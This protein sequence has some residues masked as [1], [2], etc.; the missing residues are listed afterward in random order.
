MHDFVEIGILQQRKIEAEIIKPIYDIMKRELGIEKAQAIIAEA[1]SNAAIETGQAFAKNTE[2][3]VTLESFVDLQYL[4][5]KGN[6]LTIDV[7]NHSAG[8][9]QYDVTHCRYAEM[10][11]EMGLGEIGFLLS[12]NRD[13]QFIKGYAP[14]IH[15]ERPKT[16][17]EGYATCGFH[18]QFINPRDKALS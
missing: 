9:Y 10:Y 11:H 1:I 15:L 13:S 18:Y 5:L 12:C 2:G 8:E 6:A 16:I 14:D 3:P 7:K 4:W 17:M